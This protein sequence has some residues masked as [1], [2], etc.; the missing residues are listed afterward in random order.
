[1]AINGMTI[2]KFHLTL[3]NLKICNSSP[4]QSLSVGTKGAAC[5]CL[6]YLFVLAAAA[7]FL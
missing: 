6:N 1:M 7:T 3:F 5:V 2:K 4:A